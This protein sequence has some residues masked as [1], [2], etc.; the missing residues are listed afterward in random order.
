MTRVTRRAAGNVLLM[1]GLLFAAAAT[2]DDLDAII[3][4]CADCHGDNGVS[5][6]DD[7][8]TIAGIDAFVGSEALYIY[9]DNARPCATVEFRQG[10]TSRPATNMCDISKDLAD[11][12]IEA[13]AEH[14]SG[15]PFVPAQQAFDGDLAEVGKGVHDRDCER[16]HSEGGS[17]AE[18]EAG[19]LAGQWMGYLRTSF[20]EYAAGEREQLDK[21]KKVMDELSEA[22][23]EALLHYYAS[24]Q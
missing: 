24:Q 6:W 4:S 11:E 18:D 19:I 20:A 2:A 10:D 23:I 9:R 3:E 17:N 7:M 5:S 13:L 12:T 14:F 1:I 15:L 22:D 16:C 21:M 8:P